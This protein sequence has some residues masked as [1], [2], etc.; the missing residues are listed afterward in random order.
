VLP[1]D[2]LVPNLV[3]GSGP[4]GFATAL[5]LLDQGKTVFVIDPTLPLFPD[6]QANSE[7]SA[8]KGLFGS[9]EMYKVSPI[10]RIRGTTH[11]I[12]Y[13]EARGGLSTT[14]GAGL[15]VYPMEFF[16]NWPCKG[17]GMLSSYQ[18]LLTK[19]EHI[20][21]KDEIASRFPWPDNVLSKQ[22]M[23]SKLG[24]LCTQ[25]IDFKKILVGHARLAI[26]Q[27]GANKCRFCAG[28]L[29]GC[30]YDSIF[31]SGNELLRMAESNFRLKLISGF[32]D[33]VNIPSS[34]DENF[35]IDVFDS[36]EKSS[37]IL[38]ENV[39][40]SLGAVGTPALLFRSKIIEGKISI[41]DSQ[42]FYMSFFSFK[43]MNDV[44]GIALAKL[45]IVNKK[46][47]LDQFHLSLYSPNFGITKRMEDKLNKL[48]KFR[49]RIPNFF[50][51]RIIAGIGFIEP[52][53]SGTLTMELRNEEIFI[54]KEINP[55]TKRKIWETSSILSKELKK[56]GLRKIPFTTQIPEVGSGFHS[57]GG[58]LAPG[59]IEESNFD[60]FGR[61]LKNKRVMITD[62]STMMFDIAGPHTLTAM[63]RAYRNAQ[64]H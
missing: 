7:I 39:Y 50:A 37:R 29:E 11:G 60:E 36:Q 47:D 25:E 63:A 59:K 19:I 12:P 28:C 38:A 32:V 27:S 10:S 18:R 31:N 3:I 53:N 2:A 1:T 57:G 33:K 58:L 34:P 14:W 46:A 15:Q 16:E 8:Q 5:G 62:A 26:S 54:N 30:P 56:L 6:T 45:F 49:V 41:K 13:S 61:F 9:H 24:D 21:S 20:Y 55:T 4:T 52:K 35:H 44:S 22:H 64:I 48:V 43:K 51:N 40:L 42:V 17:L 23:G